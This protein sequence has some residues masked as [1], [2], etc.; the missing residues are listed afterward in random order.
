MALDAWKQGQVRQLASA[1]PPIRFVDDDFA[2]GWQL[3][4]YRLDPTAALAPFENI[5]VDLEL[6]DARG[7][8]TTKTAAYQVGLPPNAAVL[9]AD[10]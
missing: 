5:A 10:R 8:T 7:K 1:Q 3:I 4:D 2:D 9:R 6:R